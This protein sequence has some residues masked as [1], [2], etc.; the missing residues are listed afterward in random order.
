MDLVPAACRAM[1]RN[2]SIIREDVTEDIIKTIRMTFDS[3]LFRQFGSYFRS[4]DICKINT[5]YVH[6]LY[7]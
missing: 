7:I 6:C 1:I 2:G 5:M 4:F 3:A